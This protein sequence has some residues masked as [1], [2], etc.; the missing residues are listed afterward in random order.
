MISQNINPDYI[1]SQFFSMAYVIFNLVDNGDGK[2]PTKV[3]TGK[4]NDSLTWQTMGAAIKRLNGKN[5]LGIAL[6]RKFKIVCLDFDNINPSA[7]KL[8][9][10]FNSYTTVSCGGNGLHVWGYS[11]IEFNVKTVYDGVQIEAY[12][13]LNEQNKHGRFILETF[14]PVD[15]LFDYEMADITQQITDLQFRL[16]AVNKPKQVKRVD[17]DYN[18]DKTKAILMAQ[19]MVKSAKNG[20]RNDTLFRW[21]GWLKS[22]GV[23]IPTIEIAMTMAGNKAG[24]TDREIELTI[25]SATK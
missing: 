18:G 8:A 1:P 9:Q 2:K 3:P 7:I 21:A 25:R 6:Q 10:S 14:S 11:E 4:N 16:N 22:I 17:I 23:D 5:Y 12:S 19:D 13:G 15:W 24:L 20:E